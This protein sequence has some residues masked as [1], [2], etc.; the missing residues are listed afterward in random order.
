MGGHQRQQRL[1]GAKRATRNVR[2][3]RF[4][5]LVSGL[6][7]PLVL[8]GCMDAN[9]LSFA[10]RADGDAR[11][12]A[13]GSRPVTTSF[14]SAAGHAQLVLAAP[15]GFCF[16]IQMEEHSPSGGFALLA[17]CDSMRRFGAGFGRRST[18]RT[19]D[20]AILTATV[21]QVATGTPT[22]SAEALVQS[23]AA[24]G[25]DIRLLET[26]NQDHLPL[27]KL[28]QVQGS[29]APGASAT[30][31]RGV[32]VHDTH[33]VAV[34]LYAPA[35]SSYL[36]EKGAKLIEDFMRASNHATELAGARLAAPQVASLD[37]PAFLGPRPQLRP[38]PS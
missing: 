5:R 11:P 20:S 1:S 32:F 36:G 34:A 3:P 2:F 23:F 12:G 27:V 18:A 10:S 8:A 28:H 7:L 14:D 4:T 21:G 19:K 26:R 17:R 35:G 29:R 13:G 16:D 25:N 37:T 6:I 30:H 24:A 22:P 31:W 15:S 38:P 9:R 33:M